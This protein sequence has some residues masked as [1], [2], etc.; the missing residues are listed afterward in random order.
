MKNKKYK[1]NWKEGPNMRIKIIKIKKGL[2]RLKK[3][4]CIKLY[5]KNNKSTSIIIVFF[6]YFYKSIILIHNV[7]Y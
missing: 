1:Y 5:M 4:I 3:K 2:R 7:L 6:S